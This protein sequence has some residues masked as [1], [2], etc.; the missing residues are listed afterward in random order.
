MQLWLDLLANIVA[1][2]GVFAYFY[3]RVDLKKNKLF[4]YIIFK[5]INFEG[6]TNR[7]T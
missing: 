2:L 5:I 1:T 3:Q 4:T 6:T 7:I